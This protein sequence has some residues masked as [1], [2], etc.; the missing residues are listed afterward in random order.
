MIFNGMDESI[1]HDSSLDKITIEYNEIVM[2]VETDMCIKKIVFKNYIAF[3]YIGQWDENIIKSIHE[4][5]DDM[6]VGKALEKVRACNKIEYKGGGVRD[7]N[8]DWRCITIQ[9][10]DNTCIKIVCDDVFVV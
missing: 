10:I 5:R 4:R 1:W 6:L 8:S 2:E 3:E 7:I 9:L